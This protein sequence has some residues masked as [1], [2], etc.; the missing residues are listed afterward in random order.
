[1]TTSEDHD[2]VVAPDA[3]ALES[4]RVGRR[5]DEDHAPETNGWMAVCRRCGIRTD[6]PEGG[7][8][9]YAAQI[10]QAE[11]WLEGQILGSSIAR[12]RRQRNT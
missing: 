5:L 3:V 2:T 1:M 6:G 4:I 7:H 8:A 9:P 10:R 12:L 11:E